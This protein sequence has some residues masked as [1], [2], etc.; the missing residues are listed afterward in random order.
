[1]VV[2]RESGPPALID[3][4][5]DGDRVWVAAVDIGFFE[6]FRMPRVA[7]RAFRPGDEGAQTH[8][9]IVNETLA[10]NIGGP[11]LGAR[12][13]DADAPD[14]PWREVVGV[15][16]TSESMGEGDVLFVPASAAD[17]SPAL[18]A[19]H[20]RG[21]TAAFA[22]SLRGIA[23][24]VDPGL[25]VY[26]LMPLDEAQRRRDPVAVPAMV[27][28]VAITLLALALSAA[29]LYSL[30]SVAVT[31]RTREIGI[32]I[33]L[34]ASPRAVLAALFAR[35]AMQLGLGILAGVLLCPP[36]MA[37][38][39]DQEPLR[40]MVPPMVA[41]SGCMMLVGLIACGVPARRALRVEVIDAVRQGG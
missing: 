29:G 17:V 1:L 31:R 39:G 4:Q 34:G 21:D 15:V 30:M 9:V 6:A 26:D 16:R 32:R 2:Q 23:A 37:A 19:A 33:A 40:K 24:Q 28:I 7:G 36:L 38:L 5:I 22:P 13:R 18:I 8:P 27:T 20:V 14:G 41:A 3:A 25:R 12:L 10:R 35:A 11:A